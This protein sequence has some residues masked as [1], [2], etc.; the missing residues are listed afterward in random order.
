MNPIHCQELNNA[1]DINFV[2]GRLSHCCKFVPVVFNKEEFAKLKHRYFDLNSE[3]VKARQDLANGIQ[4]TRCND[5]WTHEEKNILSWRQIKNGQAE[6]NTIQINCQLSNLCNQACFYCDPGLSTSIAK[7]GQWIDIKNG[8]IY[9]TSNDQ[10][11][12]PINLSDLIKFIEE[13]PDH[14]TTL[15]LGLTGGEPFMLENFGSD[16]LTLTKLF[17]DKSDRNKIKIGIS[18]NG[19]TKSDNIE[20][21]YEN[22]KKLNIGNRA[23]VTTI[24]SIENLE[25]RAEYVRDGLDWNRFVENFKLHLRL[26]DQTNIRMTFNAFTIVKILDFIKFFSDYNVLFMY[27]YTHQNF[28]RP[29]IL[30]QRF[31]S[32]FIGLEEY[33]IKKNINHRFSNYFYKDLKDMLANDV[34]NADIFRRAITNSD[35]IKNK[36]WRTVFPEYIDWFDKR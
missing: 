6:D 18:T 1:Y 11:Q 7:Y 28:F 21:F 12:H 9:Q 29:W 3:T 8:N 30:D 2:N 35:K 34:E 17:L 27:N 33:L 36:N 23:T 22:I 13:I 26:A 10:N 32:E 19:N 31:A 24:C 5:C 25:E 15:D 16:I 20:L 14:I 4:T